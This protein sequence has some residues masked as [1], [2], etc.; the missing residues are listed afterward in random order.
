MKSNKGKVRASEKEIYQL[1]WE[2]VRLNQG[3]GTWLRD[4][5][6]KYQEYLRRCYDPAAP[7]AINAND[8]AKE[9]GFDLDGSNDYQ[10]IFDRFGDVHATSFDEWWERKSKRRA[11]IIDDYANGWAG[12]D[13][14][15]TW[16]NMKN[17]PSSQEE[18][19]AQLEKDFVE[20]MKSSPALRLIIDLNADIE[21]LTKEFRRLV[22]K[23]KKEKEP[24]LWPFR[25]HRTPTVTRTHLDKLRRY[26]KTYQEHLLHKG[27]SWRVMYK[28]DPTLKKEKK[29]ENVR[30]KYYDDLERAK[31][32]I[33]QTERGDF[34]G[35]IPHIRP[36]K[37]L[38]KK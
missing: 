38:C 13:I 26:L 16:I 19:K 18:V 14:R 20:R 8:I 23:A 31:A 17:R 37:P 10:H 3:Y 36:D 21:E 6:P 2:C 25:L 1:W 34:P 29:S 27:M 9:C 4:E 22:I 11:P 24:I 12:W 35:S 30:Q 28:I 15:Q 5:M 32:L 33:T 7:R